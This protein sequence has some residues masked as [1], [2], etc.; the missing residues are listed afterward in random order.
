MVTAEWWER[1]EGVSD[2]QLRGT[3]LSQGFSESQGEEHNTRLLKIFIF[4]RFKKC[5]LTFFPPLLATHHRH[6]PAFKRLGTRN[7]VKY[8]SFLRL[9]TF[10]ICQHTLNSHLDNAKQSHLFYITILSVSICHATCRTS[11]IFCH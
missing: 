9:S 8:D 5:P 11:H 4:L 6:T 7:G 2:V 3:A 1:P 10:R